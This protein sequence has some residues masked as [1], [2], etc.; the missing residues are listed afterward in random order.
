MRAKLFAAAACV[1][2]LAAGLAPVTAGAASQPAAP[3]LV[4]ARQRAHQ[5]LHERG[6]VTG[7]R[8]S[9][10]VSPLVAETSPPT[11][12]RAADVGPPQDLTV[13]GAVARAYLR[14][15]PPTDTGGETVTGYRIYI[16]RSRTGLAAIGTTQGIGHLRRGLALR[17]TYYFAVAAVTES[18]EGERTDAVAV[19]VPTAELVMA[20]PST[21]GSALVAQ[22][23]R[24]APLVPILDNG[25]NNHS[26]AVSPDGRWLA[27]VSD[28]S[29]RPGVYARLADGSG[30]VSGLAVGS[31]EHDDLDFLE[32]S[33]S[34]DSQWVSVTASS[35]SGTHTRAVRRDRTD[36]AEWENDGSAASWTPGRSVV[37]VVPAT[38]A[39]REALI[40]GIRTV[41]SNA[42]ALDADVS[43]DGEWVAYARFEGSVGDT[44]LTTIRL[45]SRY[46]GAVRLL[47]APGGLNLDVAWSRTGSRIYFTHA[48]VDGSGLVG[49]ASVMSVKPDGTG[50]ITAGPGGVESW[51]PAHR[52]VGAPP[53][54]VA[55]RPPTFLP[56]FDGDGDHDLGIFR[57]SNGA[58]IVPGKFT[59]RF[60][61]AGDVP[62]PGDFDGNGR[63][64][65][66]V[67]RPSTGTW[68]VRGRPSVRLGSP[69]DIPV[70]AD[71]NADGRDE[72]AVWRPSNGRWYVR[73]RASV[74]LG[75]RG[76]VPMPGEWTGD[77]GT[78]LVVW[79][80]SN[81]TWYFL[82]PPQSGTT[83]D[84]QRAFKFGRAGDIPVRSEWAEPS[85]SPRLG[86]FRPSTGDYYEWLLP[87]SRG[88]QLEF[89]FDGPAEA[90]GS[91][92]LG[93]V[94][95]PRWGD[96]TIFQPATG[97]WSGHPGPNW[98]LLGRRGDL[99]L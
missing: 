80:P 64:D 51:T 46:G 33:W 81:G 92:P 99:P 29:G 2:L 24:G 31:V 37:E 63:S 22:S 44:P 13:G 84:G 77:P 25:H 19:T 70:P 34:A 23:R 17:A 76:D 88:P 82:K 45:V 20:V 73:G 93:I 53:R 96:Y 83:S 11:R 26:P 74:Q 75:Q 36:G 18:G 95:G 87:G 72:F 10:P 42:Q 67:Y 48:A 9:F 3:D 54:A 47:A 78:D 52:A 4:R 57:P 65:I 68:H 61:R 97:I 58:W 6:R 7:P 50:L 98:P 85:P 62:V 55:P 35:E 39:L 8:H 94:D 32:P 27:Y 41:K 40:P 71:Y 16:G 91:V 69:G 66:A 56:D 14:W 60:G 90:F 21:T 15:A 79:R 38:G 1:F 59:V 89:Q 5:L 30:G 86:I 12:A 28:S 43:P 49:P